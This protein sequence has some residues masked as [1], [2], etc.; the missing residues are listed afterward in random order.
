MSLS[1]RGASVA[2]DEEMPSPE[3]WEP[4]S[5][6]GRPAQFAGADAVAYE[7]TVADPRR[8]ADEHA[9][10]VLRGSYAQTRVWCN[11]EQLAASDRYVT[12]LRVRLPDAEEYRLLVECRRPEHRFGGLHDTDELPADRCVPGIWWDA[13]IETYPDPFVHAMRA[14][15][16]LTEEGAAVDVQAEVV[17]SEP[18]DDRLTFSL[19]PAG[20]VR[21]GGMM[22]RARVDTDAGE[23]TVTHTIDV[24]DPTLW[25]PHDRGDQPRYVVRAKLGDAE[26]SLTT[27]LRSVTY[28]DGLRVNGERVRVRGV[29]LLDPTVEDVERAL[30][31][32]ANLVRVRAQGLP[33]DV[34]EACDEYGLLLWQDLPLTGPGGFDMERG[35]ELASAFTAHIGHHPSL[36]CVAVHDEPVRPY[37]DGLGSGLLDRLR[38]RFR[39]WRAS[40]NEAPATSVA[41]RVEGV[42]TFPVVGPPGIDPDAVTL[43]PGWQYGAVGDLSWLCDRYDVGEVVAGFGAGSLGSDETAAVHDS[44]VSGDSTA[45]Q[46]YQARIVQ[47]VAEALRQRESEILLLDSLRDV[48][49]AGMGVLTEDGTEKAAY[50]TVTDSYQPTQVFLSDPTPGESDIVVCHDRP[51]GATVTVEWD[52]NGDRQQE[53]RI[54]GEFGRVTVG[55]LTLEA[56]DELTLAAAVERQAVKNEYHIDGDI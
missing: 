34:A 26:H 54:I 53:E 11:G 22:D 36:A 42:P 18:I 49:D 15:P 21:G 19:R 56:G 51:S 9:V 10:L 40:Y 45:S 33:P 6:P 7:T 46:T 12:P 48:G 16:R 31:A 30:A 47:A 20:E 28:D 25:W 3:T 41:D 24:R 55:S 14:R 32:N 8:G 52:H 27:G 35:R 37:A 4:V 50:A 17:T 2:P 1:W 23:R 13:S 38:F 5:V 39:A 43:Y 44:R 29:T